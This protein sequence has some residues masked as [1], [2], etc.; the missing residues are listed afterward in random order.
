MRSFI[1]FL[2]VLLVIGAAGGAYYLGH[3]H[4]F[5]ERPQ[6]SSSGPTV[7][8][9]TQL[10]DLVVLRV[11]VSDVLQAKSKGT[12]MAILVRGDADIAVDLS[13]AE[14]S[15][16]NAEAKTC[17]ITIGTPTLVRPRVDHDRTKVY[18]VESS[19]LPWK[20]DTD[21]VFQDA[22]NQAQQLVEYASGKKEY[23]DQARLQAETVLRTFYKGLGWS[24]QVKWK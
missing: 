21:V 13:K 11:Q 22:M 19:L 4:A 12:Q 7:D 8:Q 14:I 15:L 5:A 16:V 6:Y 18:K 17:M 2:T 1:T 9:L 23:I 10:S 20:N 3:S 24:V